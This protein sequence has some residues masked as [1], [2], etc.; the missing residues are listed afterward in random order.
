M[1]G[2]MH[3]SGAVLTSKLWIRSGG[4]ACYPSEKSKRMKFLG[5]T[6]RDITEVTCK[7]CLKVMGI[8]V[9]SSEVDTNEST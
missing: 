9:K 7:N 2:K 4:A 3:F 1:Q 5:R 8:E 6:T